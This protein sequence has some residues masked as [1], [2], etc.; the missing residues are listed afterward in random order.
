MVLVGFMK[1]K[2]YYLLVRE[3][4]IIWRVIVSLGNSLDMTGKIVILIIL[5]IVLI[6][7]NLNILHIR[8]ERKNI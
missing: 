7:I 6:I 5:I 1:R 2:N 4:K 8:K 3:G